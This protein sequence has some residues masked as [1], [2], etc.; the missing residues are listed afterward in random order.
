MLSLEE[1]LYGVSL[2]WREA[3]YNFPFWKNLSH[4][5]WDKAYRE[6]VSRVMNVDTIREYYLELSRFISL[7]ND[8]HSSI[9]FPQEV[10][11]E[12]GRLPVLIGFVGGKW[13][14]VKSDISYEI[15]FYDEILAINDVPVETYMG[16]KILPYCWHAKKDSGSWRANELL[17]IVEYQKEIVF[18]TASGTYHIKA[19]HEDIN[20]RQ[21]EW[22]NPLKQIFHSKTHTISMTDDGIAVINIPTFME[23]ELGAEFYKNMEKL[24][25]CKGIILDVR[26]NGGGNSMYAENI[27]QAFVDGEFVMSTDKKLVHIGTYKAWGKFYDLENMDLSNDWNKKLYDICKRQYFECDMEKTKIDGCPFTFDIPLVILIN[28]CTASSAEDMVVALD[29][30]GRGKIVGT[31]SYG[32]TGQPLMFDLPGNGG[33]RI[34]T[35]WC[36]Y[37]DGKD[38]TN[39]GVQ[40]QI[41]VVPKLEDMRRGYDEIME[42]GLAEL[43]REMDGGKR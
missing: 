41:E 38:F 24:R 26:N 39:V 2:I 12:A 42:I 19:V 31:P 40:P 10:Y 3:E 32:S 11:Q 13:C 22:L 7:L 15:P 5:D 8:G 21:I 17:P 37:P 20:W 1:K 30:I 28:D 36:T 43:R 34:C 14:I 33:G 23:E 6:C 16:E 18:K 9:W 29:A 35:I 27:V 4:L 25:D